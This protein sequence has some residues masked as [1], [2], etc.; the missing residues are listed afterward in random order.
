MTTLAFDTCFGALSVACR[1]QSP[2]GEWL[3]REAYEERQT[4]H[5]EALMPMID[6]VLSGAGQSLAGVERIA[7]TLGPGTFTGVR[8]G[9][10][11]ARGFRLAL[12]TPVVGASSLAVMAARAVSLLGD[13][14]DPPRALYVAV[15]A[16]RGHV[17]LQQ[18]EN[19]SAR[20]AGKPRLVT[21]AA[22]A[23]IVRAQPALVCGSG[24]AAVAALAPETV[25]A[26]LASLQPHA[27]HLAQMAPTLSPL[28]TVE[29]LYLRAPDAKPQTGKTLPRVE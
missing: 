5:A 24:A 16:R 15:D 10:A 12:G 11:A 21:T 27:R 2:A 22:A 6:E 1:W 23:E 26:R 20:P 18:F 8:I 7:V 25:E 4:G 13:R 3:I 19:A 28:E 17:F 14:L 29:P 9:V